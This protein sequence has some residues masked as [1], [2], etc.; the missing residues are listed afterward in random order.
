ML[1]S[2]RLQGIEL[3]MRGQLSLR[4]YLYILA[5][6]RQNDAF[7][8][9]FK[10]GISTKKSFDDREEVLITFHQGQTIVKNETNLREKCSEKQFY[11]GTLLNT[12][13]ISSLL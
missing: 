5:Q 3:E 4:V 9:N 1:C 6:Y 2:N 12:N 13:D 7:Y 8:S 11:A 10:L